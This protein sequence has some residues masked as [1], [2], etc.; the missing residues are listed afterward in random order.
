MPR[1]QP[2][3][4]LP[5]GLTVREDVRPGRPKPPRHLADLSLAERREAVRRSLDRLRPSDQSLLRMLM[6]EPRPAYEEIAATLDM[7]VGSIGPT[8]AR[9]LARL[10][11]ERRLTA[12]RHLIRS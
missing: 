4:A 12:E 2:S 6:A 1:S 5:L 3:S 11:Q 8:R 7:P 10:R 9:A